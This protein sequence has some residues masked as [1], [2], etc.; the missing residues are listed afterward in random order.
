MT[1]VPSIPSIP[2]LRVGR[3]ELTA[4][5]DGW[6]QDNPGLPGYAV[7][8][9]RLRTLV[10]DGRLPLHTVLP[11]E[12]VLAELLGVSRTLTTAAYRQLREQGFAEGRHGSGTWTTLPRGGDEQ[13]W[14]AP[15]SGMGSGDLSTAAPE[16]PPE[17]HAAFTAA[18]AELPRLMP[19]HG[20]SAAGLPELRAAIARRYTDRGLPTSAE[21]V[22]VTAGAAQGLRL[23]LAALLRPGDRVLAEDPTWPQ[24]LDAARAAGGRPVGLPVEQGW[25]A[26]AVRD[27]VRRSGAAVACLMPDGQNPTGRL[28]DGAPRHEVAAALADAGC[29]T[30][31]DE[32]LVDFDLRTHLGDPDAVTPPPFG[33]GGRPG[34]VVHVGSA[35]KTFWGGLRVG[36]VRAERSLAQ[37]LVAARIGDDL[38][39]PPLEQLATVQLLDRIGPV[40]ARRR[41]EMAERCRVLQ[42]LL[43]DELPGWSASTP[44]AGLSL[45]CRLPEPTG[46]GIAQA[47]RAGGIV[48]AAGSRF[49]V[50]GG[51]AG[52]MRLTFSA[53][54]DQ[55]VAAVRRLAVAVREAG[56]AGAGDADAGFASRVV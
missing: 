3:F 11:S 33:V 49:G 38:G 14:L 47:A 40:A 32:T 29:V 15:P 20:Y 10:L 28:L 37:R 42:G 12:R 2:A 48:L 50:D 21:E 13:L 36:W 16:A 9:G 52:R 51:F 5:L 4:L 7:L 19:G 54:V 46:A 43:T 30:L 17:L 1:P 53:P 8:A 18:L 26:G 41:A 23:A 55:L 27:L 56:V 35:S 44:Q 34:T 22:V 31:V 24:C 25:D 39:G 45:W 6:R